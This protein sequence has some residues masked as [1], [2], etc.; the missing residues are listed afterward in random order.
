MPDLWTHTFF[1]RQ[2]RY[3]QRLELSFPAS[4]Y[5]GAQG[6]DFF[7]Y[8]NF[9]PWVEDKPG[10]ALGT[11]FHQE[12]TDQV[13]GLVQAKRATADPLLADY[14]IGFLSHYALDATVHPLIHRVRADG[15]PHKHL[16]MAL[17]MRYY[18]MRRAQSI[19]TAEVSREVASFK[20][21]P[22]SIVD[23]YVELAA[24][25]FQQVIDP[26]VVADSYRD[27]RRFHR[28]TRMQP[29]IKRELIEILLANKGPDYA[30]YF[31]GRANQEYMIDPT[32][33]QE[34]LDR[35]EQAHACFYRLQR[36]HPIDI[37]VNFSG[38]SLENRD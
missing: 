3:E 20:R 19:Q 25:V 14:L 22:Q 34:Y 9:W 23:F 11:L 27:F 4:Y 5:L 18:R 12:K 1:A 10:I 24:E 37:T 7:F 6:P 31:Y 13:I 28:I 15:R 30:H 21:L 35:I 16:E 33:W 2:L 36:V 8:H 29:G 26:A 32:I 38:Y 17:D